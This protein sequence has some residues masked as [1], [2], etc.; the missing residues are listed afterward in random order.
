[1]EARAY[2]DILNH[3]VLGQ[4]YIYLGCYLLEEEND[5]QY[6]LYVGFHW[7][8][9]RKKEILKETHIKSTQ[10]LGIVTEVK[11]RKLTER[12][13]KRWENWQQELYV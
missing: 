6:F 3:T 4:A 13:R 9:E 1:M 12:Y 5:V 7:F 8:T 10:I 2:Y 11:F